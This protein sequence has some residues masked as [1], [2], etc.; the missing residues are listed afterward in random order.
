MSYFGT[1]AKI[2]HRTIDKALEERKGIR[3]CCES[4]MGEIDAFCGGPA[5]ET[6]VPEICDICQPNPDAH[7]NIP[8]DMFV[9]HPITAREI[10]YMYGMLD[11]PTHTKNFSDYDWLIY[12]DGNLK[13]GNSVYNQTNYCINFGKKIDQGN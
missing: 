12:E 13:M 1:I 2:C 5:A 9:D 3:L 11:C 4:S 7:S 10:K 8:F 6:N